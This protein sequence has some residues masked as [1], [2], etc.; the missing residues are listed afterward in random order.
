MTLA[1]QISIFFCIALS[2][3][4]GL[5]TALRAG[6]EDLAYRQVFLWLISPIVIVAGIV[7]VDR[8]KKKHY[9]RRVKSNL[10]IKNDSK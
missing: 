8:G 4:I 7:F 2:I 6:R 3:A 10:L 1:L 9:F 5:F